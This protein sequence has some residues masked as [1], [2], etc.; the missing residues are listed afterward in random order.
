MAGKIVVYTSITGGKDHL[1]DEQTTGKADFICFTD[2][3][4]ESKVWTIKP[5]CELSKD[6]NRNAK[7]HKVLAHQYIGEYGYSI[8]I[9]GNIYLNIPPEVLIEKYLQNRDIAV[10]NHFQDRGCL[11]KE[12][13]ACIRLKRDDHETIYQQVSSY[14]EKGY[15]EDNGLSECT[16]ILRRHNKRIEA[17][18]NDWWSEISRHS[19]RDQISFNFV[20]SKLNIKPEIMEGNIK[21]NN[22]FRRIVHNGHEVVKVKREAPIPVDGFVDMIINRQ[23]TFQSSP[24]M[25]GDRKLVPVRVGQRWN[26]NGIAHYFDIETLVKSGKMNARNPTKYKFGKHPKVS[27]VVLVRNEI[28]YFKKCFDSVHKYTSDYELIVIDNGAGQKTKDY[29]KS[30]EKFNLTVI[31]NE[32]NKGFSYG[33]DQG[34]KVAKHDYICFLNSDTVVT[35]LWLDKLMRAFEVKKDCG[36]SGPSTSFCGS[37]QSIKTLA[38]Q[39]HKLTE[40]EINQISGS[41]SEGIL[42]YDNLQGFCMVIKKEI[43]DK[44]GVFN[45]KRFKLGCSE[46]TEL[47]WRLRLLTGCQSYWVKDAYVHHFGDVV[48]KELGINSSAYNKKERMKWWDNKETEGPQFVENDVEIKEKYVKKVIKQKLQGPRSVF[49]YKT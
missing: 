33:C 40:K 26:T 5:A 38:S 11:Y 15:P 27:I 45:Y 35:P 32:E 30:L 2:R 31:T 20:L 47:L 21:D 16:V 28:D 12:A 44:G 4:I 3:K 13:E 18:N 49:S 29:L 6:S 8:W 24:L 36:M 19:Y 14:R 7:I 48:F 10:F 9:D 34:I 37:I 39:R 22:Y 25:P 41:L 1:K 43:L 42:Q 23:T 17:F 46:E